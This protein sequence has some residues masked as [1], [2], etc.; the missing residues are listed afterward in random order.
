MMKSAGPLAEGDDR[1]EVYSARTRFLSSSEREA[2]VVD[3]AVVD[4][5]AVDDA[6]RFL[7]PLPF[8]LLRLAFRRSF[9]AVISAVAFSRTPGFEALGQD[10]L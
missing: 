8:P 6:G 5:A 2:Y 9:I 3:D 1:E 10:T 7:S 4:D